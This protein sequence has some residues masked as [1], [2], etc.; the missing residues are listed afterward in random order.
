MKRDS[1][2]NF[3]RIILMTGM[4][5]LLST[6]WSLGAEEESSK[7]ISTVS[8]E[9]L[10]SQIKKVETTD[11]N[12]EDKKKLAELYNL[13]LANIEKALSYATDRESFRQ[14]RKTAPEEMEKLSNT[15]KEREEV[16]PEKT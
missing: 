16:S 4:L 12:D 13:A 10:K 2:Q 1:V 14:A 9:V 15:L 8:P 11:L 7:T 5:F 3:L 6:Q